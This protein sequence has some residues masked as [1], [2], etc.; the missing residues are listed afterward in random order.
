M[1]GLRSRTCEPAPSVSGPYGGVAGIGAGGAGGAGR[2]GGAV[3]AGGGGSAAADTAGGSGA[4]SDIAALPELAGLRPGSGGRLRPS[5]GRAPT[6]AAGGV[7][8]TGG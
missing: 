2:A 5:P 3:A 4:G 1:T 6:V 7:G 8:R